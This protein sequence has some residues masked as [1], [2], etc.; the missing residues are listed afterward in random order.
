[1]QRL[2]SLGGSMRLHASL[3][4]ATPPAGIP[5]RL[6][7]AEISLPVCP[8]DIGKANAIAKADTHALIVAVQIRT[9]IGIG[10]I[11]ENYF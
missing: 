5:I 11:L 3:V 10:A 4:R 7:L 9:V 8:I 6:L 1:M 2:V